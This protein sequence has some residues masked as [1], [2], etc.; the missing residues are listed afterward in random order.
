MMSKIEQVIADVERQFEG[1][2]DSEKIFPDGESAGKK[3]ERLR[4][5]QV[6]QPGG[7]FPVPEAEVRAAVE[8]IM[9]N[10]SWWPGEEVSGLKSQVSGQEGG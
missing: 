10:D 4:A 7:V 8:R 3:I 2:L 9:T 1:Y 5:V 6:A